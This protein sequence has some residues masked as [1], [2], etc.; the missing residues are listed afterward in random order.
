MVDWSWII[1]Q[2]TFWSP[3]INSRSEDGGDQDQGDEEDH[4]ASTEMQRVPSLVE[5]KYLGVV[6]WVRRPTESALDISHHLLVSVSRM[7]RVVGCDGFSGKGLGLVGTLGVWVGVHA[8]FH[9]G[10][11]SQDGGAVSG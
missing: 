3:I 9:T 11:R 4:L 10:G 1:S 8:G 5:E 6:I 2:I 7:H